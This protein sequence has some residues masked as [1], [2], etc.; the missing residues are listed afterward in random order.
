MAKKPVRKLSRSAWISGA[1]DV[2]CDGGIN[3]LRVE[4]LAKSLGVTKGSFYHHFENRRALHLAMLEEWERL[5]TGDIIEQVVDT[6]AG[7]TEQLRQLASL[8]F[9]PNPTGDAIETGIR[10]WAGTDDLVAEAVG[11][12]DALR[13]DFVSKMLHSA[14]LARPIAERRARL[15]YRVL[16][17]EF[18]WRS[19]GGPTSTT[20]ELDE[21][22]ELLL[23]DL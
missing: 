22:A 8:T 4:P 2:L 9:A 21:M 13:L 16:I 6:A 17:G 10:A 15:M 3:A 5:G 7:P 11:R 19:A 18:V 23:A 20:R 1:F 14:G 12:V